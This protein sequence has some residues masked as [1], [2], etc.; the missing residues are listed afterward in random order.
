VVSEVVEVVMVLCMFVTVSRPG[1]MSV[2]CMENA[3]PSVAIC[4]R[5]IDS[6]F[7]LVQ[8]NVTPPTVWVDEDVGVGLILPVV[9]SILCPLA[10][11]E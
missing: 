5:G 7:G 3:A 11:Y 6:R 10:A 1:V 2:S 4:Q 9:A 8:L